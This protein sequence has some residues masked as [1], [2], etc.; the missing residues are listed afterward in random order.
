MRKLVSVALIVGMMGLIAFPAGA[1]TPA[2]VSLTTQYPGL[3]VEPGDTAGF[4]LVLTA[5]AI[6]TAAL[7]V[8]GIPE[9]WTATFRGGGFVVNQV[10]VGPDLAPEV[11][12]DVLVP[13]GTAEGDYP[14]T[15]TAGEA[16]IPVTVTVQGGVGGAVTLTPE[17]P[18]LRGPASSNFPFNIEIRNETPAEVQLE[19]DAE[20]PIGWTVEARPQ[21]SSQASSIAVN[22]GS[23]GQITVSA[24]PPASV[25]AGL[26]DL[27]VTARGAGVEAE[28]ILQV[29]ITGSFDMQLTTPDQRL[30]ADVT[31]GSPSQFQVV[32]LNTGSADLNNVALSATPSGGLGG[33]FR[34]RG[35]PG[36][37]RR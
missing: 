35:D 32:V 29:E 14:L 33:R 36:G 3:T 25:D 9:G 27:R 2:A 18:G 26:Y 16:S 28:T 17:F 13:A 30:N 6:T 22:A 5:P 15:I 8:D 4:D 31:A 19:L 21:A 24:T 7:A 12:L 10:S 1:Q 23:T 20:G 37:G 34:H 11:S